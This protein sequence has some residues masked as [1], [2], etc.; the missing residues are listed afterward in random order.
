MSLQYIYIRTRI[1]PHIE[2]LH[3][4]LTNPLGA[5]TGLPGNILAQCW[6]PVPRSP[7]SV[8]LLQTHSGGGRGGGGGRSSNVDFSALATVAACTPS[9]EARASRALPSTWLTSPSARVTQPPLQLRP[10]QSPPLP[11]PQS[12]FLPAGLHGRPGGWGSGDG[13][14]GITAYPRWTEHDGAAASSSTSGGGAAAPPGVMMHAH[15]PHILPLASRQLAFL[16][17]MRTGVALDVRDSAG[18]W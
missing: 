10:R 4:S 14:G 11:P 17:S 15:H 5:R 7:A 13:G 18:T 12:S 2:F 8:R 16:S 9:A 3:Y 1:L 6:P